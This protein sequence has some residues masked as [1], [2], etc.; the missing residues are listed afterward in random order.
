M[1]DYGPRIVFENDK[2]R[3]V[4]KYKAYSSGIWQFIIETKE[5]KD[6]LGNV[7]YECIY[8]ET[9]I[10]ETYLSLRISDIHK[11]LEALKQLQSLQNLAGRG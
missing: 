11:I 9:T 6:A 4:E 10:H 2:F 8:D 7:I 1:T 3:L 5:N